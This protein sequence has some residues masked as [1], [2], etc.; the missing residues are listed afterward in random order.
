MKQSTQNVLTITLLCA[1]AIGAVTVVIAHPYGPGWTGHRHMMGGPDAMGRGPGMMM[2]GSSLEQIDQRLADLEAS[3][4]I[5]PEQE[6]AWNAYVQAVEAKMGLM[7]AHR[8]T[9]FTSGP[10]SPEQRQ[11]FHQEGFTQMQKVHNAR[12]ELYQALTPEQQAKV[13][14]LIGRKRCWH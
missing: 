7:Q 10:L 4:G 9:M 14:N 6:S 12:Q 11:A 1:L 5:T 13:A 2:S 8:Q 3:L